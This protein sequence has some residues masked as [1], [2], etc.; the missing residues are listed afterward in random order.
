MELKVISFNI[1]NCD[2]ENGYTIEERAPRLNKII[3]SYDVDIIGFQEY[4]PVWEK[5]IVEYFGNEFD[6]FNKYRAKNDKESS[7]ILWRKNKFECLKKGYFWLSDT[8][9]VESK[10]WDELY[11]CFRICT[12]IILRDKESDKKFTVMNTHFGFGD[13]GQVKSVKL[14]DEYVNKISSY[15]TFVIGD[16][17]MKP[18]SVAY[19]LMSKIFTD[20]NAVTTN[21]LRTT[22]HGYNPGKVMN[23]HIDYCFTNKEI[24][25][26]SQKIIDDTVNAMFPSDHYGLYI[27]IE[28]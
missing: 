9:N 7:P 3:S 26:V 14:L 6:I 20:V 23:S 17:N 10:G 4:T 28:I 16:F 5:Y 21:D 8:P 2:D 12:Y 15:P 22:Y 13:K 19:A 1:R 24:K 11:D 25:P 18:D 27:K